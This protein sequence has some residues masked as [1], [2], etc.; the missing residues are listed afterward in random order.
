MSQ[1]IKAAVLNGEGLTACG[2]W[3]EQEKEKLCKVVEKRD[4]KEFILTYKVQF[5]CQVMLSVRKSMLGTFP[6][7]EST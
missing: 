5:I 4:I 1:R 3:G 2:G 6:F 7:S